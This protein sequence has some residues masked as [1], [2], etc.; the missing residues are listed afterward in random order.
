MAVPPAPCIVSK[1]VPGAGCMSDVNSSVFSD[2]YLE[3]HHIRHIYVTARAH[4]IKHS[5]QC[6]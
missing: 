4:S 2:R 5:F 3:Q 6:S 1:S